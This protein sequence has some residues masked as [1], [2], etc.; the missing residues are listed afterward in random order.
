[1]VNAVSLKKYSD[2][3]NYVFVNLKPLGLIRTK[4]L[5]ES[6]I[7]ADIQ[8]PPREHFERYKAEKF[9][10]YNF[11]ELELIESD[12]PISQKIASSK[13]N[14][15]KNMVPQVIQE[16]L[17]PT[18]TRS[19]MSL[20][21]IF[22]ENY[23]VPRINPKFVSYGSMAITKKIIT[24]RKFLPTYI[25]GDTGLGKSL[26]IIQIAAK[27]KREVFRIGV[28]IS[29][30]EDDLIGG[31]R[32]VDG[33]TIF[34]KG[35][36]VLAMERGAILLIDEISALSPSHA[37]SL[38]SVLEGEELYI[39]KINEKI[40]AQPGFNVIATDNSRGK[41]SSSGRWVGVNV[42]NDA[43]LDRFIASIEYKFPTPAVELKILSLISE[44]TEETNKESIK[45]ANV[46]RQSFKEDIVDENI[47]VRRLCAI[48]TMNDI[49]KNLQKSI[50]LSINRFETE[51]RDVLI[52]LFTKVVNDPT[53]GEIDFNAIPEGN[54]LS[55]NDKN[56]Y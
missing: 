14:T 20:N 23:F 8:I 36:V 37:F 2:F 17:K 55:K 25:Y 35:P 10:H 4:E 19:N 38:F 54:E 22:P 29:T 40:T 7:K 6:C 9:G 34:Q 11:F 1:M 45:W 42:Q 31:F 27:A 48:L 51:T 13:P 26:S 5:R 39:K 44:A 50:E 33:E 24:S 53:Y 56:S 32:I 52:D 12:I 30:T 41:G 21:Q 18:P 15:I 43:F 28:N 49:F 3:W 16:D 46:V 47:S